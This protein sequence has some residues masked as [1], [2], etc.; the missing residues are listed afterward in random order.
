MHR[1]FFLFLAGLVACMAPSAPQKLPDC[2]PISGL[3]AL[4]TPG[5]IILLGEIHSTRE[6]AQYGARWKVPD[7]LSALAEAGGKVLDQPVPA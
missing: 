4:L 5:R 2:Q 7:S 1:L 6:A 3:A